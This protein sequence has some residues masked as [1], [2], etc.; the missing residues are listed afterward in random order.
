MAKIAWSDVPKHALLGICQNGPHHC[1]LHGLCDIILLEG[2]MYMASKL[3][4][5]A[6]NNIMAS[7][8]LG[9]HKLWRVSHVSEHFL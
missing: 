1:V 4:S 2:V 7:T 9:D 5:M 3:L 8:M 6:K